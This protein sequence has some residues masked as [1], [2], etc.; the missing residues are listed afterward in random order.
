[1]RKSQQVFFESSNVI[2]SG[3]IWFSYRPY[4]VSTIDQTT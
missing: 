3:S 1:M 4:Y 2:K